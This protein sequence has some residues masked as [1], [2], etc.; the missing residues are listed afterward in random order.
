MFMEKTED[1]IETNKVRQ[2]ILQKLIHAPGSTFNQLWPK[3]EIESNKFAYHLKNLEEQELIEKHENSY[4]LSQK[5]REHAAFLEGLDG[6]KKKKPLSIV[7]VV[8]FDDKGRVLLQ[9]RKK[10]PFFGFCGTS[11]SGKI[12]FGERLIEA[13]GKE[14][15]EET[16]LDAD[17]VPAAIFNVVT[18][19]KNQSGITEPGYHHIHFL[20]LGKNPRGKLL[21]ENRECILEWVDMKDISKYKLF[22]DFP[23]I[24][25]VIKEGKFKII[26]MERY[27]ENNEF[28]GIKIIGEHNI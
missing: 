1:F 20:F 26:E 16:G 2:S 19:N 8:I 6:S 4:F 17:I 7:G 23:D 13:A 27:M 24:I 25:R 21:R 3:D 12:E 14:L 22:P 11:G 18:Y 15:K 5:G 10:E 9:K 28:T